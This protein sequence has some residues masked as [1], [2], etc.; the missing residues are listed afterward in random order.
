M[1]YSSRRRSTTKQIQKYETVINFQETVTC[2]LVQDGP[3]FDGLYCTSVVP[4]D[5]VP[6]RSSFRRF[7][8]DHFVTFV[9][10]S[11]GFF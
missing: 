9:C 1:W 5:G 4:M 6:A 8:I 11:A 7:K 2:P 10:L 3:Y